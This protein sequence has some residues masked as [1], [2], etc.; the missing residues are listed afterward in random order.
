ML[1][2]TVAL[3]WVGMLG[4]STSSHREKGLD[5]YRQKNY[6]LAI[7][8]L[9]LAVPEEK[10]GSPEF[11]ESV[12]A[13]GQSYFLLSQSAKA[14]P[15]LERIPT[16][17]EA[18]YMLGYAYL[19]SNQSD[20]AV[21]AFSRLFGVA[22]SSAAGHLMAA[23]MMLKK[24]FDK[25]AAREASEALKLDARIPEAH[26]LLGEILIFR[27]QFAEAIAEIRNELSLN[28]NLAKAWYRLGDAYTRQSQWSDAI[29]HLQRAIWLN[30][31]FSGP[32]ILLG[33]CYLKQGN[34]TNAEGILRHA[35][36]L[37]PGN[38]EGNYLLGQT[39]M[40][41]GKRDEARLDFRET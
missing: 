11:Q 31:E 27:G 18:N 2:A 37:D 10:P 8:E 22:S 33:K 13:L 6:V 30:P 12:L 4:T 15:W 41:E 16:S 5:L 9:E 39:L 38:R 40:A 36:V 35:A 3:M 24:D 34:L 25:E 20:R 7:A 23:Q 17:T 28:P 21:S 14:I 19:Q 32:Y 29:P 1:L 26:F